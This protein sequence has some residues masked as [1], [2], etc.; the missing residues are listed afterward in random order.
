[1]ALVLSVALSVL[2]GRPARAA[3]A[4]PQPPIAV[5]LDGLTV[6]FDVPPTIVGGRTLVPFRLLA[7]ALGAEVVWDEADRHVRARDPG[8][9]RTVT[10]WIGKTEA[11]V[12][13][14]YRTLDVPA[15]IVGGRTLIPLRFFGEALGA[16]VAWDGPTRTITVK[17]PPRTM[18]VLGYYA[19]GNAQTSSWTELFG[20][21]Y[22]GGGLG[23]SDFVSEVACAWYVLDPLSGGIVLDDSYSGQNRPDNWRDVLAKAAGYGMSADMMVHWARTGPDGV[24]DP[25]IYTFLADTA[26][27]REAV[28]E[29]AARAADFRGV[30][31]DVEYIGQR[32]TGDDLALTRRRFTTFVEL[33]A[34]RLHADGRT[35]TLSLHAP[36][37]YYPGYDW[38]ALGQLADRVV[39]MAYGFIQSKPQPLDKVTQAVD[40]ALESVPKEKLLLGL[41]PAWETPDTVE[42]KVGLAKRRNLAGI[43]LWRLGTVGAGPEGVIRRAVSRPPVVDIYRSAT[44]GAP[45]ED[46]ADFVAAPPLLIDG[47]T[48]VPLAPLLRTLRIPFN[49]DPAARQVTVDSGYRATGS[50]NPEGSRVLVAPVSDPPD[51]APEPGQP[52]IIRGEFYVPVETL[53]ELAQGYVPPDF[54]FS[55]TVSWDPAAARLVL[56][57]QPR[58]S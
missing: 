31:L 32:Q 6:D 24:V 56:I 2:P 10:L 34:Q 7:E 18:E 33:L 54:S 20:R 11:L 52:A 29:I 23:M 37:S 26:A 35:L 9:G 36:N 19:L 28:S 25:V 48:Y 8:S 14:E 38:P 16:K 43:A 12:S 21:P 41:L 5:Y 42:A 49:F 55:V 47:R 45:V 53:V 4:V 1:M 15:T 30:N 58:T 3:S 57:R 39:I 13:G 46:R 17:S 51:A 27:M 40:L 44:G 22:P 50:G